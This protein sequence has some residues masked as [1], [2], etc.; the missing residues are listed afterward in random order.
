MTIETGT[1]LGRYEIRAKLGAG[2]MG[3]VYLA[4]D[5][6]LGRRVAI[7]LLPAAT[8]SDEHA[9]RRLVR[10]ARAAA[11][12]DHPNICAV[13]EVGDADGRSFIVM[14]YLDGETLEARIRRQPLPI[15]EALTIGS[16]VADALVDAHGHG[17]VHRDIKPANI[18]LAAR[19]QA[20]VMDFGLATVM[21]EADALASQ[22]A[23]A[24][25]LSTPG[26]L[27]GTL[28]YMSPEQVRGDA[29]DGRS[30]IFSFG[31]TL[32]EM[33]T[34]HRPF[35][36]KSSAE[37]V[38]AVLTHEPPPLASFV[39][40]APAE[41]ERIVGKALRKDP[42]ARYQTAKDLRID[43]QH[44]MKRSEVAAGVPGTR[45][46]WLPR[47]TIGVL[48]VAALGVGY[49][50][51]SRGASTGAPGSAR[52]ASIAVLPFVNSSHDPNAD[53]LSVGIAESLMNSLSQLPGL[54]VMSRN[55]TLRY[56]SGDQDPQKVGR[57]LHVENVLTGDV[58]QVG[59]QI[60][61]N[62]SLDDALDSHHIWGE[63]YARKLA[64]ILTVQREIAQEVSASL[65]LQ[66]TPVDQ[67]RLARRSTDDV[68]A[69]Q[70]YLKGRYESAKHTQADLEKSIDYF[71]QALEKDRNYALAD[72]GLAAS[73][74][75]LGN[76]Y[77]APKEAFPQAKLYAETALRIDD[78][79]ADAHVSM[80]AVR[81][82]YEWNWS[83]AERELNLALARNPNDEAAHNLRG[84][85]LKA[86]GQLDEARVETNR[87]LELDLL[88]PMIG[89]DVGVT[90]YYAH[91]YDDA[92]GQIEK[93]TRLEPQF[94]ISYL[95]LGQAYE[96]QK[97]Y[98]KAIAT[99]Q[100]GMVASQRHPQ[101]LASLA[102]TY[103]LAGQPAKA[104]AALDELLLMAKHAYV[105][106]YL[107]AVVYDGLGDKDRTF[108]W[109]DKAYRD[110]S[111]FLIWLNV[112]PRFDNLRDDPR[113]ADLVRR[114]GL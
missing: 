6:Q 79:L 33:V 107:M 94:F 48:I 100:D 63:Q 44:L 53:Y 84:Y 50:S 31:A 37:T 110:R 20:K 91:H 102:R 24:T 25:G 85:Y 47:A 109:L 114:I 98:A 42:D 106:P 10:E 51:L 49:W 74:S 89:T 77:L 56:G 111:F 82:L 36:H 12:L 26:A 70:L 112:E 65:R 57:E 99:F 62:V 15:D 97:L 90:S 40:G 4:D 41:L 59:D 64:D 5:T 43:L 113:F 32:Y 9:R 92:I 19:G 101:L 80:G 88:S 8:T 61:I 34:G 17:I 73:F 13:Y 3:E 81:L 23:T 72:A 2:G 83:E 18:M 66:L 86:R 96:Q 28:S 11:T 105:S 75:M 93:T 39:P 95:W 60:V 55:T 87:A 52:M 104:R 38:S 35:A 71:N 46:P 76:S 7:K 45:R 108:V 78:S 54:R 103:A 30:D 58:R 27:M 29:L 69:Y 68:E 14:Q 16:Q 1:R 22:A 21:P 67:Q